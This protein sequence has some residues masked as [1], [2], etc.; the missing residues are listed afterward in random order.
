MMKRCRPGEAGEVDVR[1]RCKQE[2]DDVRAW[3]GLDSE[4]MVERRES[5]LVDEVDQADDALP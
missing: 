4:G 3:G 1:T 5:V 2:L